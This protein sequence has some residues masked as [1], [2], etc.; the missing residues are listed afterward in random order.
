MNFLNFVETVKIDLIENV[1]CYGHHPMQLVAIANDGKCELNALAHLT[2]D[3]IKERFKSYFIKNE[4]DEIMLSLH[5]P[6]NDE[7]KNDFIM[8]LH[9]KNKKLVD[10]LIKEYKLETG[11]VVNVSDNKHFNVV[12]E[13]VKKLVS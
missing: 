9:F 2:F 11:D 1:N 12:I 6:K 5:F 4:H 3:N 7:I 10:L 13:I 8:M